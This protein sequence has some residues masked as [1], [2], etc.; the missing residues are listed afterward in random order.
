MKGN[1]D[2]LDYIKVKKKKLGKKHRKYDQ[3]TAQTVKTRKYTSSEY[4]KRPIFT[5]DED[6]LQQEKENRT[7]G[8]RI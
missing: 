8:H 1:I 3:Q 2:K 4:H 5:T 6:F 7:N